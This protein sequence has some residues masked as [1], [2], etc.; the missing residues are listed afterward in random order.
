ML[1]SSDLTKVV[2][3]GYL[4]YCA[5][6]KI[7]INKKFRSYTLKNN[8][9]NIAVLLAAY[10]GEQYIKEQLDSILNQEGVKLFVFVSV[11]KS[12]DST[13]SIVKNYLIN[14]PE[15][16]IILPYG[17]QYGSAGQNFARLLSEVNFENYDYVSFADQDDI[18]APKKL[19][20]AVSEMVKHKVDGY[21][22]NVT[23][24]WESGKTKL[25]KKDFPQVN[26]DYLFE[27]PG[28]GCTFV[29]T[30]CLAKEIQEHLFS[31]ANELENLWLHDWYC[32]S[33]ARFKDFKWHIDSA[34]M[35]EYRQHSSNE[36][37]ANS[38]WKGFLSRLRIILQGDGFTKVLT[39][40]SFVG[41]NQSKPIQLIKRKKRIYMLKLFFI[42][43]KCRRQRLHKVMLSLACL[44]FFI[45]GCDYDSLD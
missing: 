21:S 3:C 22:S 24:F 26:F 8:I 15:S 16:V 5:L 1:D 14:F 6:L 19:S 33:F 44:I 9:P 40:A 29:L 12:S 39:Q 31:K 7:H 43:W 38:G 37:G 13:L 10:N 34:P 4:V 18:W 17:K 45:K 23:A 28:P 41:Q 27:T 11:D 42:S 30:R 35:M 2:V 20:H 36:V 25:V 32:Y